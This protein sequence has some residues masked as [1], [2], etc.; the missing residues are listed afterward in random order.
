[1]NKSQLLFI[2]TLFFS[3]IIVIKANDPS[4]DNDSNDDDESDFPDWFP[5]FI[6]IPWVGSIFC[7]VAIMYTL[8]CM[9]TVS[10]TYMCSVLLRLAD[11]FQMEEA[12]VGVTFIAFS[13]ASPDMIVG[14]VSASDSGDDIVIYVSALLGALFLTVCVLPSLLA[15]IAYKQHKKLAAEAGSSNDA[16]VESSKYPLK[17]EYSRDCI[18]L[19]VGILS[20]CAL[21]L[22]R[23]ISAFTPIVSFGAYA[24]YLFVYIRSLRQ[25]KHAEKEFMNAFDVLSESN[26]A[27]VSA[28]LSEDTQGPVFQGTLTVTNVYDEPSIIIDQQTKNKPNLNSIDDAAISNVSN[29]IVLSNNDSETISNKKGKKAKRNST[30]QLDIPTHKGRSSFLSSLHTNSSSGGEQD[31]DH[32]I[33]NNPALH[34]RKMKDSSL[35]GHHSRVS[36]VV[37]VPPA[38]ALDRIIAP[39]Q[40]ISHHRSSV[41]EN[42]LE[43]NLINN[44]YNNKESQQIQMTS[45]EYRRSFLLAEI[46]DLEQI[47]APV[48]PRFL[49]NVDFVVRAAGT[50]ALSTSEKIL[51]LILWPVRLT[52]WLTMPL[53]AYAENTDNNEESC[54]DETLEKREIDKGRSKST[55]LL[56]NGSLSNKQRSS[57]SNLLPEY[58]ALPPLFIRCLAMLSPLFFCGLLYLS[59]GSE[60]TDEFIPFLIAGG[61]LTLVYICFLS[62]LFLRRHNQQAL[63]WKHFDVV[64]NIQTFITSI[65]WM[66]VYAGIVLFSLTYLAAVL[67]IPKSLLSATALAF[68]NTVGDLAANLAVARLGKAEMAMAATFAAPVISSLLGFGLSTIMAVVSNENSDPELP[69]LPYMDKT[70]ITIM[71]GL[72]SV[73]LIYTFVSLKFKSLERNLSFVILGLYAAV[74]GVATIVCF[75]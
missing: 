29:N 48:N 8:V 46:E 35:A 2:L 63:M 49:M 53:T 43:G 5:D 65:M 23:K 32:L 26:P 25:K 17:F 74:L 19:L 36:Q 71:C 16:K 44:G 73:L 31:D 41:N 14:L 75:I 64:F 3:F 1:M 33:V 52:W 69:L 40:N 50:H 12:V 20:V 55:L 11:K 39:F 51:L 70:M 42:Q 58:Q 60:M 72:A 59:I 56:E 24:L 66:K 21:L 47:D 62:P 54:D 13:N 6:R 10:D 61:V 22:P 18:A 30:N 28:N 38:D 27:A 57:L 67:R 9:M 68:G 15:I 45:K 37:D 34:A 4:G 7:V